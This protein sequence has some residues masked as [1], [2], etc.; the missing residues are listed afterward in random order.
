M[1]FRAAFLAACAALILAAPAAAQ[2]V[3]IRADDDSP[4][5]QEA[6]RILERRTYVW[7]D[8]DT[9]LGPDFHAPADLVVYRAEVRLE[10]AVE[11]SVLVLDG[12][13]FV[14]PRARVGGPIAV[15]GGGAYPSGLAET[16]PV[17]TTTPGAQIEIVDDPEG[18]GALEPQI[19]ILRP[20]THAMF[21][22]GPAGVP[23]Y[24]RVNGL[25]VAVGATFRPTRTDDGAQFGAWVSYS[26][27]SRGIGA[28]VTADVPLGTAGLHIQGEASRD[29][30]TNDAWLRSDLMN[31]L[32]SLFLG[33]DY[34]DY[35]DVDRAE[36]MLVR[37]VGEPLVAGESWI[38][39]R[40]GVAVS[41]DASLEALR[42][43]SFT[44][45]DGLA[46]FN[47]PVL[48]AT[49]A[50][51]LAGTGLH[52]R[53]QASRIDADLALEQVVAHG[54]ETDGDAMFPRP[55]SL[56]FTHGVAWARYTATLFGTHGLDV[57]LRGTTSFNADGAPP[58]RWGILG[59]AT[60]LPTLE[61]AHFRGD[62]LAFVETTY[63]LPVPIVELPFLGAPSLE[64]WQAAGAAWIT[65]EPMPGWVQNVGVG[66]R[67][68]FVYVRVVTDPADRPLKPVFSAGLT[69]PEF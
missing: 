8:R 67:A 49:Y 14:R 20:P 64:L 4:A 16:G 35:H 5:A 46:R 11:G 38:A 9:I 60:T 53:G 65:D 13:F 6:R 47:P 36:L 18:R 30:R 3:V 15:I 66:I 41:R 2:D 42:P 1:S 58:Q 24:D 23:L 37:P 28:G 44:G 22:Y 29:T 21:S 45:R 39:P 50:S 34:R 33:T 31:T 57:Y 54:R 25:T 61:I 48:E 10:G 69:L 19:S 17:L 59:G 68:G 40:V 55:G 7:M 56:P 52:W 63:T 12:Q 62:R 26:T 32:T 43:W 27:A 51:V